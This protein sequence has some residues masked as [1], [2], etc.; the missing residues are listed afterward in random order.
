MEFR[1]YVYFC[2][3]KQEPATHLYSPQTNT[4][5]WSLKVFRFRPHCVEYTK[6]GTYSEFIQKIYILQRYSQRYLLAQGRRNFGA[7][8]IS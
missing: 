8:E 6:H 4:Y 1:K 2:I 7:P 3:N 5:L